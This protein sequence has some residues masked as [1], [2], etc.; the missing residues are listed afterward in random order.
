MQTPEIAIAFSPLYDRIFYKKQHYLFYKD[1]IC[2]IR[3]V[4]DLNHVNGV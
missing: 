3:I 2:F 1:A 4:N